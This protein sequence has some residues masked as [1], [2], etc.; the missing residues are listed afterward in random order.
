MGGWMK[1]GGRGV[2]F[3]VFVERAGAFCSYVSRETC[4]PGMG[5]M[6]M[7]EEFACV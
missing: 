6:V 4:R 2:P 5:V 7:L 3:F 1:E